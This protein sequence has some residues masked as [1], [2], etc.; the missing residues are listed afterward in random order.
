MQALQKS[1]GPWRAPFSAD[2]VP[3]QPETGRDEKQVPRRRCVCKPL[4]DFNAAQ[5]NIE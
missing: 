3:G 4:L 1:R 5:E 2:A